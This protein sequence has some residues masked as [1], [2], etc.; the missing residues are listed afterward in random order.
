VELVEFG[1]EDAAHGATFLQLTHQIDAVDCP[2]EP[3]R[4]PYRQDMYMRHSWEGEPGR[5]FVGYDGDRPV[6]TA[7][8]DASDYDNLEMAWF[9]LRVAP[10]QRRRGHGSAMLHALEDVAAEMGRPLVGMDGWEA[11][12]TRAFAVAAGYDLRSVEVRRVQ[13]VREA[14]DPRPFL[15]EARAAAADYDLV[16]VEGYTPDDLLRGVV[17][18]TA[19]INDAPF[20]D[21][22]W[23]DE[24]YSPGRVRAY[25]RAQIESGFRFRRIVARHR[26]SGQLAGHTVLVV[27][28]EQPSYA[29]QHDTSVV[30]AHRGHRLGLLLKAEML[31]W[32]A[33]EEPQVEQVH[34]NNAESNRYMIEVND[35]LGYRPVARILQFQRRL[36][37]RPSS[38][39]PG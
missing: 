7:V 33:A 14:P 30:R 27:D 36:A 1:R 18:L 21:L 11:A 24:V 12:S 23:E 38:V 10:A 15:D 9:T 20:D 34:T 8:L 26:P 35:R 3:R 22:E 16:H 2:W 25:E 39:S 5:W 6:G 29:E 28:G 4:T 37:A 17:E 19:A 31:C 32:L 13:H